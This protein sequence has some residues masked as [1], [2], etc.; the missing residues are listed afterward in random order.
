MRD[1]MEDN[2]YGPLIGAVSFDSDTTGFQSCQTGWQRR[3]WQLRSIVPHNPSTKPAV[4]LE[5]WKPHKLIAVAQYHFPTAQLLDPLRHDCTPL[6]L[7][8]GAR[9]PRHETNE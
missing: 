5:I 9:G 3:L 6:H 8:E 2:L 4:G 7:G 1:L